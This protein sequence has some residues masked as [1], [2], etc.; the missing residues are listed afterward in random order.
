M[1]LL[2]AGFLGLDRL[3]VQRTHQHS[4]QPSNAFHCMIQLHFWT[5]SYRISRRHLDWPNTLVSFISVSRMSGSAPF[6]L[7]TCA[8]TIFVSVSTLTSTLLPCGWKSRT[9]C[10]VAS[11]IL[12]DWRGLRCWCSSVP[13]CLGCSVLFLFI[14]SSLSIFLHT[15]ALDLGAPLLLALHHWSNSRA[16]CARQL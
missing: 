9:S 8:N 14:S 3:D 16:V 1:P 6:L 12:H 10:G 2:C 7:H 5:S 11:V 4:C 13:C 15:H